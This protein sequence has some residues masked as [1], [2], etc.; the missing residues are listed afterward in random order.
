[1]E[2]KGHLLLK[3]LQPMTTTPKLHDARKYCEFMN[4]MV[5]ILLSTEN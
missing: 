4:K 2:V 3:K 5:T 1:M